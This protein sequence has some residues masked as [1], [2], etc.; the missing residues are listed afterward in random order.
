M[1]IDVRS[2]YIR[3]HEISLLALDRLA[4][5]S[6]ELKQRNPAAFIDDSLITELTSEG[7]FQ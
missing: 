4:D 5:M 1:Q 2:P 7:F 3:T 6:P